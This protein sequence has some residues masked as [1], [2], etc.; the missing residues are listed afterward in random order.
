MNLI[1][2]PSIAYAGTQPSQQQKLK[3]SRVAQ[4]R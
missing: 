2:K 3:N 4:F 1:V